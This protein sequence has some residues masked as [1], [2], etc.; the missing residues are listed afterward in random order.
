[1]LNFKILLVCLQ[2]NIIFALCI[3]SKKIEKYIREYFN[4][5]SILLKYSTI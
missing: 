3:N 4:E 5:P 2:I 1:M